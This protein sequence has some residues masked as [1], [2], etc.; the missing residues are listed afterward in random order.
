MNRPSQRSRLGAIT[1]AMS[2]GMR[3][4]G[5]LPSATA[6]AARGSSVAAPVSLAGFSNDFQE[7]QAENAE[8]KEKQGAALR[9]RM[10]LCDDGDMHTTPID[11]ARVERLKPSLKASGQS[12]PAV[13][14]L[15]ADGR[16]EILAGRHRKAAL[17]QLGEQEWDVVVRKVDDDAAEALT[18]YDNLLA[19]SLTDFEKFRGFER[20][21]KSKGFTDQQLA[22]ESGLSRQVVQRLMSFSNLGEEGLLVVGGFSSEVLP[23]IT[24]LLVSELAKTPSN[25]QA[26]VVEG[27]RK[28]GAGEFKAGDLLKWVEGAP[29]RQRAA[30]EQ[31][32]IRNGKATFAKVGRREGRVVVEFTSKDDAATLEKDIVALIQQHVEKLKASPKG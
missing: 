2:S 32:V 15:K 9:V 4:D 24:G 25:K 3:T 8:L 18:F 21:K 23:T 26:R 19:P 11:Q 20:R 6:R 29:E 10:E 14:R 16:F 12:S 17:T 27:L 13:V 7:L 28:L 31:Q 30:A 1:E 22:D 5:V